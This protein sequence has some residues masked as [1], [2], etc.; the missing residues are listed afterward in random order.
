MSN[1]P[2]KKA[3]NHIRTAINDIEYMTKNTDGATNV[4]DD[5]SQQHVLTLIESSVSSALGELGEAISV[6]EGTSIKVSESSAFKQIPMQ[7]RSAP[8]SAAKA[9]RLRS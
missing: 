3:L 6:L 2:Y 4:L 7:P 9:H 5:K 8:F 1:Q